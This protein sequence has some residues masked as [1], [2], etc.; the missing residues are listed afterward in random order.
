MIKLV[1]AKVQNFRQLRNIDISF[2]RSEDRP[3]TVIRAENGTGKTTL[4]TALS[5]GLFDDDALPG[6]R[7]A[8]RLHPLDWDIESNGDLC[9]VSVTIGFVT[10]DD[11]TG[12]ERTYD[13][14]R[15][16]EEQLI[17]GGEFNAH[18]SS[19]LLFEH[20]TTGYEPVPNP[21]AFIANRVLPKSLKDVFF[22]DGDRALA[23]IE[24]T[25]ERNAK[26]ERVEKAVRQL[27]GLDI[28][29]E[30]E[31]H[32][33]NVRRQAVANVR[34]KAA[35]T[36]LAKLAARETQLTEKLETL[37]EEKRTV[38]EDRQAT[39]IRKRKAYEALCD[40]LAA[41]GDDRQILKTA[42][43]SRVG[44]LDDER[45][46]YIEL[47]RRQHALVNRS[48]VLM[49]VAHQHID[50]AGEL[51]ST[52]EKDGVI[53]DTLPDV[54]RDRLDRK[55]CICGRDV[56][57]GTDGHAALSELLAEIDKLESSN[58]IL[59]HLSTA[60]R[61]RHAIGV[62]EAEANSWVSQAEDSHKDVIRCSQAQSRLEKEIAEL[63]TR[64]SS[65]PEKDIELLSQMH[66]GEEQEARRLT[67][68][69]A[70]VAE[71]IRATGAERKEAARDRL[72]AQRNEDKYR[73]L[74]A[75]E[76]AA[77]DLLT[78]LRGT[79]NT[80]ESETVDEVSAMM[81]EIF[82]KMIVAD[83]NSGGL[84]R[85][86]ELT[87]QHDILV[88]GPDEQ[89]MDPDKDLSGAQRRALT[90]A[91]ILGLI[92]VSGVSGPNVIDTPLGMT[93]AL[94]RRS[95]LRYAAENSAQLIIFLTGS[96]MYGVEDIL[97]Q[98]TGRTYTMSFT[99]HYPRQLVNDPGTDRLETLLCGCDYRSSCHLCERIGA[100]GT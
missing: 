75:E 78:V 98:Y 47:T 30:A 10:I 67:A 72:T 3:V 66:S 82:L 39:E 17:S 73:R 24:A 46:H 88:Y 53:P 22:I 97:D 92:R 6:R 86:A 64:I 44:E 94:V 60:V 31:R 20:K 96:E 26:R 32:V 7:A 15:K 29:E 51:L 93:S 57:E 62:G 34:K 45:K 54:V 59:L 100:V 35:G 71:R 13:L 12:M 36:N 69:A 21:N 56:S 68:D 58:E 80:L 48:D 79:V 87:P 61:R 18:K 41:G 49:R 95:L 16:T 74:L 83:P 65:I 2:A 70:K 40:A 99:D 5:W 11:E 55:R 89:K 90:L 19:L 25:D 52:L 50:C 4:L 14:E 77:N 23:F 85:R 9:P 42:L 1:H 27:L 37:Q 8:Y 33:D 38:E 63:H 91:F 84:I 76:I 43:A 81:N 28:L